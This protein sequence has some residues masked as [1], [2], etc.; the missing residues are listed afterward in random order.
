MEF[1]FIQT[2]CNLEQK[3]NEDRR[4]EIKETRVILVGTFTDLRIKQLAMSTWLYMDILVYH[5]NREY[6]SSY[7]TSVCACN[8][9]S[10]FEAGCWHSPQ[11]VVHSYNMHG[12]SYNQHMHVN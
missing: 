3:E 8:C 9:H 11:A 7:V 6:V 12:C 4:N 5:L 2:R 1:N 10:E